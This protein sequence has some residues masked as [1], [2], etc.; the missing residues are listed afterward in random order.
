MICAALVAPCAM[1][2]SKP[3]YGV[4]APQ[5][6]SYVALPSVSPEHTRIVLFRSAAGQSQAPVTL[7]INERYHASLQASAFTEV[8]LPAAKYV[9]RA[10]RA[11]ADELTLEPR[12]P[13]VAFA[14][15]SQ[16]VQVDDNGMAT[17]TLQVMTTQVAEGEMAQA[18]QQMHTLSRVPKTRPC[19]QNVGVSHVQVPEVITHTT[20]LWFEDSQ[21]LSKPVVD[22]K[23]IE[24]DQ[25][26]YKLSSRQQHHMLYSV[27]ISGHGD[28]GL[29]ES[30]NNALAKARVQTVREQLLAQGV[31]ADVITQEWRNN[32]PLNRRVQVVV[33]YESHTRQQN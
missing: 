4:Q 14:G 7:Y 26:L 9:L 10:R 6:G 27:H 29:A 3:K 21:A 15:Q 23:R 25:L 2:E 22:T 17:P 5:G 32:Q 24:L 11:E 30:Q 33:M 28:Q 16:F 8:C 12:L 19:K 20:E 13:L 1:A 18:R 31:D